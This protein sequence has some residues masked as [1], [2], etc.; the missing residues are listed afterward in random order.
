MQCKLIKGIYY[1]LKIGG[2]VNTMC[3]EESLTK[4]VTG[5]SSI[6]TLLLAFQCRSQATQSNLRHINDDTSYSRIKVTS[7]FLLRWLFQ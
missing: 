3:V 5:T 7:L 1:Q 4:Q 2:T 6:P